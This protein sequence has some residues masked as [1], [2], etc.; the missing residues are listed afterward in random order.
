MIFYLY[1]LII[2]TSISEQISEI[3]SALYG[4][5]VNKKYVLETYSQNRSRSKHLRVCMDDARNDFVG[6]VC[7]RYLL[8]TS[9]Q[10]IFYLLCK[11]HEWIFYLLRTKTWY[12][13]RNF[14]TYICIQCLTILC[15]RKSETSC[16]L[17]L[18]WFP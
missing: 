12:N 8:R 15:N 10:L 9:D 1:L 6:R 2:T 16:F 7:G 17:K 4:A 13:V 18:S 5:S 14:A 11:S 3:F